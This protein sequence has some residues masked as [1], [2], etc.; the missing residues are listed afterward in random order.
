MYIVCVNGYVDWRR[1]LIYDVFILTNGC[2]NGSLD[3]MYNRQ[4]GF[5]V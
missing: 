3:Q 4:F 1:N 5:A 2:P